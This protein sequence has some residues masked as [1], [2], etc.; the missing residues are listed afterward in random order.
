MGPLFLSERIQNGHSEKWST[1][2]NG[3]QLKFNFGKFYRRFV[4]TLA[5]YSG[6]YTKIT[7]KKCSTPPCRLLQSPPTP[8]S[9]LPT[10]IPRG[11][12]ILNKFSQQLN[13]YVTKKSVHLLLNCFLQ[14]SLSISSDFYSTAAG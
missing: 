12:I 3:R 2:F 10:I 1:R 4:L 14:Q 7:P 6:D 5:I 8:C 11:P 13:A 9:P